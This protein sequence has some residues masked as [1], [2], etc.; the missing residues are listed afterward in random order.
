MSGKE[1]GCV[2]D[3]IADNVRDSKQVVYNVYGEVIDPSNMMPNPN[4]LPYPGQQ[5]PLSVE[6]A[7]VYTFYMSCN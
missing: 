7:Q 3:A 6:R 4:Q 5:K 2:S 1:E